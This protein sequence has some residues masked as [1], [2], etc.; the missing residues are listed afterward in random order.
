MDQIVTDA[1]LQ[2]RIVGSQDA[3]LERL[4]SKDF[5]GTLL[6]FVRQIRT[7]AA[8]EHPPIAFD[9]WDQVEARGRTRRNQGVSAAAYQALPKREGDHEGHEE[10]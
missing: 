3:A 2:E 1:G 7:V 5:G 10:E 9:F 6:G 8:A 4:E